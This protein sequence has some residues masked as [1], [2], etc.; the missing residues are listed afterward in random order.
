MV[1]LGEAVGFVAEILQQFEAHVVA[2]EAEGGGFGLDVE[3]FFF[4]GERNDHG[5][6]DVHG[7]EDFHGRVELAE[8]AVDEDDVGIK[9][10]ARAGFAIAARDHFLNRKVVVVAQI[11]LDL[12]AAI[13]V[14]E[15]HAVD[16]ADFGADGF[17]A[18]KMGDVD[19]LDDSRRLGQAEGFLKLGDGSLA[20]RSKCIDSEACFISFSRSRKTVL[21]SPSRNWMRRRT[22]SL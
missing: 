22:S 12:V 14:F 4:L 13:G 15:G 20:A 8:A 3:Q 1:V 2:G 18:L 6:F 11:V 10:V 9:L 19:G 5:G 16:E 7:G 21:R 17:A